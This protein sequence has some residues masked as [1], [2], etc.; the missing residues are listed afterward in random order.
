MILK[1]KIK[2][3]PG[4]S[5]SLLWTYDDHNIQTHIIGVYS[6]SQVSVYRTIG[7][8]VSRHTVSCAFVV[9]DLVCDCVTNAKGISRQTF[10][11]QTT[12]L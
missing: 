12:N 1:K 6:R 7:P 11:A 3:I 4:F 10:M 5:L 2:W 8:L 9:S